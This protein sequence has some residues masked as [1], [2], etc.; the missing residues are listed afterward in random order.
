M[1]SSLY[2]ETREGFTSTSVKILRELLANLDVTSISLGWLIALARNFWGT[3]HSRCV[4]SAL[5]RP[6]PEG[7]N[8]VISRPSKAHLLALTIQ[9]RTELSQ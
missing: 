4:S 1:I 8:G 9:Q 7:L 2:P 6:R 5:A 3:R